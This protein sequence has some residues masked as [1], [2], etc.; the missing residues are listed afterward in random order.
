MT[1][2]SREFFIRNLIVNI[3][4]IILAFFW[5]GPILAFASLLSMQTL[6][7]FFP[8]LAHIAEKNEIIRGFIQGTLPTL[9]VSLFNILLPKIMIGKFI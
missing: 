8:W 2:Q 9:A 4:I 3:L 5:S 6:E 7:R 1:I